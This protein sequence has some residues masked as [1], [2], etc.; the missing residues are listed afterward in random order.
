MA[1]SRVHRAEDLACGGGGRIPRLPSGF[2][3]SRPRATPTSSKRRR[4]TVP[5][6]VPSE[7][8]NRDRRRHGDRNGEATRRGVSEASGTETGEGSRRRRFRGSGR[9]FSSRGAGSVPTPALSKGGEEISYRRRSARWSGRSSGVS[10]RPLFGERR[11][12]FL[13]RR[14]STIPLPEHD[15]ER[16]PV[17][18]PASLLRAPATRLGEARSGVLRA[19]ADR[20]SEG[21]TP[22][23]CGRPGPDA[24]RWQICRRGPAGAT[25]SPSSS[26]SPRSARWLSVR[27]SGTRP[28]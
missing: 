28:R 16:D 6:G 8:R 22:P 18:L 19:R 20:S 21:R 10:R 26:A 13:G 2:T 4:L 5:S 12:V 14:T 3:S 11:N 1:I 7:G 25:N 23:S 27:S 17:P 24:P 9:R 15:P